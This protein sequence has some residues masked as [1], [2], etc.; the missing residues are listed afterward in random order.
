MNSENINPQTPVPGAKAAAKT[1]GRT[2]TKPPLFSGGDG[3]FKLPSKDE[4]KELAATPGPQFGRKNIAKKVY[5]GT[6]AAV[7][8]KGTASFQVVQRERQN[9]QE[10]AIAHANAQRAAASLKLV[11]QREQR[12]KRMTVAAKEPVQQE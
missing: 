5:T 11:Q 7:G 4:L 12:E 9:L 10:A 8:G 1:P 3:A 6:G 2:K